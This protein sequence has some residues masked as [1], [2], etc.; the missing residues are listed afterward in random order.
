MR[1]Y[2]FLPCIFI[3]FWA[4]ESD[5]PTQNMMPAPVETITTELSF[6]TE[7]AERPIDLNPDE[8]ILDESLS[9]QFDSG[10]NNSKWN[11]NPNDWGP[12]SW[13][14]DNAYT[15][16]NKLQLRIRYEE[17]T[18][19]GM[20][21]YYKS[22]IVRSKDT[23]SYGFYEAKIKGLPLYPTASPAFWLYSLGDDLDKWGLRGNEEG[24]VTYA[25][26]DVVELLQGNWDP[27]TKE[28]FPPEVMD[29]NLHVAIIENGKNV[30][31]RPRAFPEM[32]KTEYRAAWDPRDD[33]HTYGAEVNRDQIIF[34]IDGVKISEKENLYWHVPMRM[35]LSLGLRYPHVT[36]HNCPDGL[37]RCPV[38]DAATQAGFP[39]TMEVD[40]VRAYRKK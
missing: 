36:Y 35:T 28:R 40:W 15:E 5:N 37:W 27:E 38:P 30:R 33:Y 2:L 21:M 17:H 12:W 3:S 22:G 4:C 32:L 26:I 16:D 23:I 6:E 19:R 10:L 7:K 29:C 34:Y 8:W 18:A 11:A 14:P 39:A 25:E 24:D 9:D 20:D 1:K 13:E 31:K